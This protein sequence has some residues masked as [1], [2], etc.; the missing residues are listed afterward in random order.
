MEYVKII[1]NPDPEKK[2]KWGSICKNVIHRLREKGDCDNVYVNYLAFQDNHKC[3][4]I[5]VWIPA[6]NKCTGQIALLCHVRP[7]IMPADGS[8]EPPHYKQI[9]IFPQNSE[10][11]LIFKHNPIR[12]TYKLVDMLQNMKWMRYADVS[13]GIFSVP[14]PKSYSKINAIYNELH[15]GVRNL[16]KNMYVG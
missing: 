13:P 12:N 10:T 11:I 8:Y 2:L 4:I 5:N 7:A 15:E 1:C 3:P 16:D 9:A 14:V 6:W